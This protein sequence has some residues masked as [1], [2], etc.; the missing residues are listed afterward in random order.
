MKRFLTLGVVLLVCGAVVFAISACELKP[1]DGTEYYVSLEKDR[2]VELIGEFFE[3]TLENPDCIVT[4]KDKDGETVYT[5]TVKG[6]DSHTVRK[7]GSEVYAFKKGGYYYVATINYRSGVEERRYICS[8]NTKS[9]YYAGTESLTMEDVYKN[10]YCFFMSR[11][12][13]VGIAGDLAEENA[14]F[15]CRTTIEREEGASTGSLSFTYT[16]DRRSVTVT[17]S[18]EDDLVTSVH[19]VINDA[20]NGESSDLTWTFANGGANV[21]LPDTD[22]WE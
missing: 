9:G 4:C 6:T 7:D 22:A 8:D 2:S 21:S 11:D 3:Q 1:M 19:V 14:V 10:N 17:A 15:E 13:G 16:A 12:S 18:S 20:A 5:E